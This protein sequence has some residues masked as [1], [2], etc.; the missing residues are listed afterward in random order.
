[1]FMSYRMAI[2]HFAMFAHTHSFKIQWAI[3]QAHREKNPFQYEMLILLKLSSLLQIYMF[4]VYTYTHIMIS[5]VVY[6]V[7]VHQMKQVRIITPCLSSKKKE[8]RINMYVSADLT[9]I[10]FKYIFYICLS[11]L[12]TLYIIQTLYAGLFNLIL[13]QM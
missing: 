1:M 2:Q 9:I 7:F 5:L 8:R 6:Y 3:R 13:M 10:C 12:C 11:I 4:S